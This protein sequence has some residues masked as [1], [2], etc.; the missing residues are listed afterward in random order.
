MESDNNVVDSE[1]EYALR[2]STEEDSTCM[3]EIGVDGVLLKMLVHSGVTTNVV[4][5][6]T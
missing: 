2:I 6:K 1:P 4:D 3:L 5:E